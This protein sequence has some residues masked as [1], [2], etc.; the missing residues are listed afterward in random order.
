[1]VR[2]QEVQGQEVKVQGNGDRD[3]EVPDY[4]WFPWF[5]PAWLCP[6]DV[7][8]C[9]VP[10]VAHAATPL[11][12]RIAQCYHSSHSLC[13]LASLPLP[14]ARL[15]WH[16]CLLELQRHEAEDLG[17]TK[18]RVLPVRLNLPVSRL[19][20][21]FCALHFTRVTDNAKGKHTVLVYYGLRVSGKAFPSSSVTHQETKIQRVK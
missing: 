1:M 21:V 7:A 15:P 11:S 14:E 2:G 8:H 5:P 9:R 16:C 18:R 4:S 19:R 6:E 17:S 10:L 20:R 12:T 3:H 13:Y